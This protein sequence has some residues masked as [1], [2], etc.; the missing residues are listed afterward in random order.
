MPRPT[1]RH[2]FHRGQV[3]TAQLAGGTAT[4]T[5][6]PASNGDGTVTWTAPGGGGGGG[7]GASNWVDDGATAVKL[8]T[9]VYTIRDAG[10]G[11]EVTLDG[12]FYV[13]TIGYGIYLSPDVGKIVD[14]DSGDGLRL[15]GLSADPT[16]VG[17]GQVL[18]QTTR[19]AI[20][21]RI[22][23]N[24]VDIHWMAASGLATVASGTTSIV[25]THGAGFDPIDAR[26][27]D[28][29]PTNN[30]TNDPGWFWVSSIGGTTFTINVRNNPGAT[31]AS[32]AW[33]VV[34]R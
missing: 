33:R 11:A 8:A 22:N 26:G 15:P 23:G 4:A 13:S 19:N 34:P 28:L 20:R 30:P 25:V 18:Y 2:I 9:G 5:Y 21:A 24:W 12:G 29:W 7:G 16:A 27:V 32:F 31:G 14:I 10:A 17:D 6:V 3:P 1:H